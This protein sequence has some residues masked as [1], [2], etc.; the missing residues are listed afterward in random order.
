MIDFNGWVRFF[1][2][3]HVGSTLVGEKASGWVGLP[4]C[5]NEPVSLSACKKA[6]T[7]SDVD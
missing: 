5:P 3:T 1:I 2:R 6:I 4:N 7:I